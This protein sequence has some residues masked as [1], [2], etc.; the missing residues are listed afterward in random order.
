MSALDLAPSGQ[1]W[2]HGVR[3]CDKDGKAYGG[4]Q[5][6]VEAGDRNEAPDWKPVAEC[7]NGLY[8]NPEGLG[9]WSLLSEAHDALWMICRYDPAL[10]VDLDGKVKV[11]WCE[12]IMTSRTASRALIMSAISARSRAAI[13]ALAKE[14]V[15]TQEREC[16]SATG[17]SGHASATGYRGHASATGYSGH[18]SA[19]GDRGHA[20]A[21]GYSGHASATGYRGHASATG[22]SGHASATGYSGHASATGYR[23]HASATGD[24]GHASAT[25][26]RG[27][28]SAT[29][30]R[31]HAS[32][33]GYRGHASATGYSACAVSCGGG[34]ARAS[35]TGAIFLTAWAWRGDKYVMLDAVGGMVGKKLRGVLIKADTDYCLTVDGKVEV[36][37]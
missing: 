18:A 6:K 9:D 29:G 32:A 37:A 34:Y 8:L 7:G 1:S 15:A 36:A 25:G 5:W 19:T 14:K 3:T 28:A 24:W 33:T 11:P 2:A 22:D 17:D 12:V 27:H 26:Y 23:G 20:S 35:A 4:F 31:G 21:T 30:D 16:A 10:A 13:E